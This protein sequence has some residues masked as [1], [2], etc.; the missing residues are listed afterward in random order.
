MLAF[1]VAFWEINFFQVPTSSAALR[2]VSVINKPGWIRYKNHSKQYSLW[3]PEAWQVEYGSRNWKKNP[4]FFYPEEENRNNLFI[5]E[6]KTK[7]EA[8][9][10]LETG[11]DEGLIEDTKKVTTIY[12]NDVRVFTETEKP[13]NLS[14][15]Y[16]VGNRV[17]RFYVEMLNED[18]DLIE[19]FFKAISSFQ[20]R[21]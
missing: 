15:F 16:S 6:V 14:V 9:T 18:Q 5:V 11:L 1:I 4:A 8:E 3:V 17:F 21:V 7:F 13:K 19:N 10:M 2:R 20:P 12:G